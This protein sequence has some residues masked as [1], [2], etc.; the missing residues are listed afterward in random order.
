MLLQKSSL[1]DTIRSRIFVLIPSIGRL[2]LLDQLSPNAEL[3]E[4]QKE[5]GAVLESLLHSS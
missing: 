5:L 1:L 2:G 4:F 3:I